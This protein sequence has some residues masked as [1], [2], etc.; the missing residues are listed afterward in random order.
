MSAQLIAERSPSVRDAIA[1][2]TRSLAFTLDDS[3]AMSPELK[4]SNFARVVVSARVS[5]SGQALPQ[6]GDRS[7]ASRRAPTA[8]R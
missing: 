6:A 3:L 2:R 7:A 8:V 4:L 1:V 5:R